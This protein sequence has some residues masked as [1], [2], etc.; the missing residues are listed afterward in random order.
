MAKHALKILRCSHNIMFYNIVF[1]NNMH[2]MV[3]KET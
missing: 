3:K 1:Y 2:E